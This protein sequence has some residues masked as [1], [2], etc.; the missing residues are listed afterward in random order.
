MERAEPAK[1]S[2][3]GGGKAQPFRT[4]SGRAAKRTIPF[5]IV[6]GWCERPLGGR[7]ARCAESFI[8]CG[9]H[10]S[11]SHDYPSSP[12]LCRLMCDQSET[13]FASSISI[14]ALPPAVRKVPR[15]LQVTFSAP[16]RYP[17]CGFAARCA[18]DQRP[19][20]HRASL[21]RL[22]RPMCGKSHA[23]C[24]SPLLLLIAT[25][26]PSFAARCAVNQKPHLH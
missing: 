2:R 24:K 9:S 15:F 23:F 13:S 14:T 3:L 21:S 17:F 25:I 6:T 4:S 22:C 7:A 5:R 11:P 20:L 10:F 1:V 26:L 8:L 18:V 16:H 12:R 19:C